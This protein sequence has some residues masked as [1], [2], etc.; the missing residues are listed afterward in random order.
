MTARLH[1]SHFT[2]QDLACSAY[3]LPNSLESR[4]HDWWFLSKTRS[5]GLVL[6]SID[7]CDRFAISL[8]GEMNVSQLWL[9][10]PQNPDLWVKGLASASS[11]LEFCRCD[12]SPWPTANP[13]SASRLCHLRSQNLVQ[14]FLLKSRIP[15]LP[16]FSRVTSM[17]PHAPRS[18]DSYLLSQIGTSHFGT[19][20]WSFLPSLLI[21]DS[22][23]SA[24]D[25][26]SRFLLWSNSLDE[27]VSLGLTIS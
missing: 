21:P 27:I 5:D 11:S 16:K 24:L 10:V 2:F 14:C 6:S 20:G 1:K 13:Q 22:L 23:I 4:S 26:Q 8:I 25:Q 19:F 18:D 9:P 15:E 17:D 12:H 3:K 7:S